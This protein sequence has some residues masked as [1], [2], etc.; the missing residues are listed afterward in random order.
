MV[1]MCYRRPGTPAALCVQDLS[2]IMDNIRMKCVIMGDFNMNML[3]VSEDN[4]IRNFCNNFEEHSFFPLIDKPTRVHNRSVSLL[5]QIFVNFHHFD[6]YTTNILFTGVTD[7]FPTVFHYKG[8]E[9][10]F[11]VKKVI[12]FRKRGDECDSHFKSRVE[13]SNIHD[14][15]SINDVNLAY[16]KFNSVIT[17]IYEES[18]PLIT[19]SISQ[20]NPKSPWLTAGIRQSIRNKNKLYKKFLKRPITYGDAYRAYRNYLTK[21]IKRAKDDYHRK[22]FNECRGNIKESWRNLNRLLGKNSNISKPKSFKCDGSIVKGDKEIANA[23]NDYY[24]S[25]GRATSNALR[26]PTRNFMSY[27][28]N[29]N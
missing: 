8:S 25:V 28:P 6:I 12:S 19:K 7:H 29:N 17:D 15:L 9:R 10:T 23:F 16:N 14:I 18:Y 4:C 26:P 3:K 22:K 21:I 11:G 27:M 20:E 13:S 2:N 1:G 5:D 24:C